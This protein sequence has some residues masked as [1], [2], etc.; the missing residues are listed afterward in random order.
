ME[1]LPLLSCIATCLDST[2]LHRLSVVVA[3]MLCM[4][5]R[6]TMLGL[7][8]WTEK[9]GSYRTIQRLFNTEIPWEKVRWFLVRSHLRRVPDTILL[10]GDEVVTPK[11]GKKTYG[12]GRFFSSIQGQPI[13]GVCHLGL[14]LVPVA[15]RVSYPILAWSVKPPEKAT[16]A[17]SAPS[18]P[19]EA[20]SEPAES[21]SAE[22]S[23]KKRGRPKGS[24]HRARQE[25]ELTPSQRFLQKAIQSVLT[26]IGTDLTLTYFV[27][28]GALGHAA[29]VQIVRQTNLHLISKL[30]HDS[31]LYRP[32]DGPYSG[33]GPRK[34]YGARLDCA[35]PPRDHLRES[36]VEDDV[37]TDTD[38]L[39]VRHKKFAEPLNVVLLVKTHLKTH[40]SAHV[41]LFSSDLNLAWDKL[42][43]YSGL[44]F[45]IEFNFRDAKQYWGLDDFMSVNERPAVNAANLAFFMVNVSHLL[46]RQP[47][48][49]GMSVLDLKAWFRAGQYVRET[50][51]CLPEIPESISIEAI[52]KQVAAQGRVNTPEGMRLAPPPKC[53]QSVENG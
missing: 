21:K 6:V 41:L 8:R 38:Q 18:K 42:V 28:D 26:L 25:V 34:K 11:S 51:K 46:R 45:Q 36:T 27:D 23:P 1:I 5:G 49:D 14:S 53:A 16:K 20:P 24:R 2:T 30:R 43:D 32:H 48:F 19:A 12:L 13:P 33:R 35:R 3:A 44:R 31:A 29:G 10:A 4:T 37:R 22:A 17:Q 47:E 9:G 50:L 52:V 7:S 40:R 15:E 39:T